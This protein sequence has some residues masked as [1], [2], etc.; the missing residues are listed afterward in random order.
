MITCQECADALVDSPDM[1]A[2]H[3]SWVLVKNNDGLYFPAMD[4]LKIL[5]ISEIVFRVFV[6]G[7]DYSST[8]DFL[9]EEYE[10]SFDK[11]GHA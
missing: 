8:H 1:F 3:L 5:R 4:V 10:K 6:S 11:S 2:F 9:K 7:S